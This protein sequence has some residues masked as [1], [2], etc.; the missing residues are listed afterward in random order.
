MRKSTI[1]L[2]V[3]HA[4]WSRRRFLK[5]GAGVL[6]GIAGL[7][8]L[9]IQAADPHKIV[10]V[11][12]G[13][14]GATAA[15]YFKLWARESGLDVDVTLIDPN[16]N[17]SSP[18]LSGMVVTRQLEIDRL[19]FSFD[20]L[21]DVHNVNLL[22]DS[23]TAIDSAGKTVTLSDGTTTL[24]YDRLILAPGISF[25]D[26]E[27]WDKDKIPHGWSG[28]DQL[29]LLT[30][31]LA[32]FPEGGTFVLKVPAAPY[33]CPPGPYERASTVADYLQVQN[34]NAR[35]IVL[36]AQ[37]DIAI[38]AETFHGLYDE[39]GVEYYGNIQVQR[40]NSGDDEGNGKSITYVTLEKDIDGNVIGQSSEQTIEADV[41][42]LIGDHKAA[43][44]IF[45]AG[46]NDGNWAPVNPLTYESTI[47]GKEFIHILGDSQGTPIVKAG[48]AANNEAKVCV[49]AILRILAGET[50]YGSP[51]VTV[52]CSAPVTQTKVNWA[53][54]IWRYNAGTL[55]ME[56]YVGKFAPE[57]SEANWQPM[58]QWAHNL[59]ADSFG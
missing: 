55:Q 14:G 16:A 52:G 19:D 20:R 43:D 36:D 56:K 12:G 58:L 57:P 33:R 26:V 48:Q 28:R 24:P 25:I 47:S 13:F 54:N 22:Q 6:A 46:L 15:K 30:Q 17:Y 40:V 8:A 38:E 5:T 7:N 59:F 23:V 49:D 39:F 45:E 42:N 2:E 53:G 44:L 29:Q 10:V 41:I 3:R 4:M 50:P 11:G 27:G 18:V 34:K 35:V 31:Q 51:I 21:R 1:D 32:D 9:P 37:A